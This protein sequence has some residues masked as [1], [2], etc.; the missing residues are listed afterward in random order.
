[1]I[2]EKIS[3]DIVNALK[4][5]E[6]TVVSTL[7]MLQASIKNKE[8]QVMREI[9]YEEV[10]NVIQNQIKQ[11]HEAAEG[12]SKG[13]RPESASKEKEEAAILTRYLPQQVSDIEMEKVVNE[14]ITQVGATSIR[15]MGK[16]MSLVKE[17][18]KGK[19]DLGKVS[20]LVK[21]KL[22]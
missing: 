6:Q 22:S 16:V 10:L 8:I 13:G 18:L 1:M 11:R 20:S 7:R 12:F 2:K 17:K 19:A 3:Q 14:T 5:G 21:E 15:E 4:S 9:D